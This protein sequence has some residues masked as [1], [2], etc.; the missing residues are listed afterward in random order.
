MP[1]HF[2]ASVRR[3]GINA[4]T[5]LSSPWRRLHSP[6]RARKWNARNIYGGDINGEDAAGPPV[7]GKYLARAAGR[8]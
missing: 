4:G 6:E 1:D 5:A 2:L 7:D 3:V 8:P